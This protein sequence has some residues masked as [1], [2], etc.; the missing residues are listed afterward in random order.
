MSANP[1]NLNPTRTA[2]GPSPVPHVIKGD[3]LT[4]KGDE[5]GP[6]EAR[7]VTPPLDLN[8]LIWRR[9][10]PGPA[11]DVPVREIMDLLVATG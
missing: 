8:S 5:Y 11:F 4:G 3:L 10:E 1:S 6:A 9:T 2:P 7:F